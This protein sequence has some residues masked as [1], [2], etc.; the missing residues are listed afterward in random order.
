MTVA[1]EADDGSDPFV[2][3]DTSPETAADD[4]PCAYAAMTHSMSL[5]TGGSSPVSPVRTPDCPGQG[6]PDRSVC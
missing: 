4:P 5:G 6:K 1:G 3:D 2:V